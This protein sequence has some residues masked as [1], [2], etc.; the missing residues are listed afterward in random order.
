[1]SYQE[2]LDAL[3]EFVN[4]YNRL[5]GK[6][7]SGTKKTSGSKKEKGDKDTSSSSSSSK[8]WDGIVSGGGAWYNPDTY[9]REE[10]EKKETERTGKS[11]ARR[12]AGYAKGTVS[13]P[14][15]SLSTVGEEGPELRVVNKG[16]GIIPADMTRNLMEWGKFNPMNLLSRIPG[17]NKDKSSQ[18]YSFSFDKLVLPSVNDAAGFI[19]ALKSESRRLAVQVQSERA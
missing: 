15:T 9:T 13:A 7:Q 5:T 8:N 10:A 12:E 3:K 4:E 14:R 2:R 18:V 6:L 16:D 11:Q 1:M 19:S 17:F